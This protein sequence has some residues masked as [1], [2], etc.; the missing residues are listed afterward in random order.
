MYTILPK[1]H[2]L[3]R[4][5]SH[6][7]RKLTPKTMA[8]ST[9][10]FLTRNLHGTFGGQIVFRVLGDKSIMTPVPRRKATGPVGK[11]RHVRHRFRL[12]SLW[13]KKTIA[14][15]ELKAAYK[16]LAQGTMTAYTMAIM[17]YLR[18]PEITCVDA[19]AY[20]GNAGEK[21]AVMATD[22]YKICGVHVTLLRSAGEI[23]EEGECLPCG[24][25][26]RWEYTAKQQNDLLPGTVILAVAVNLPGHKAE[27]SVTL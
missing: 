24:T 25:V 18:P 16:A 22:L 26:N 17:N 7:W 3:N 21:I 11:Q 13:A 6:I 19:S 2:I 9:K 15:P 1:L 10:N 14:D 27:H 4:I 23:L 5:D 12:A 20:S 8:Y